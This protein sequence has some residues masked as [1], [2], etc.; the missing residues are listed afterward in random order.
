M[1]LFALLLLFPLLWPFLARVL[2]KHKIT[3]GEM[4][5]N[6]LVGALVVTVGWYAGR[7]SQMADTEILNG[8]VVSKA[9]ERVSCEHD[10]KCRCRQVCRGSGED[11]KCDEVCDTCY[12]HSHDL[13]WNLSTTLGDIEIDRVD[14][15][16]LTEPPRFTRAKPGD[17]VAQAHSFT[18]YIRGA[19][20]SLFNTASEVMASKQFKDDVPTY[21]SN[22]YDYHYVDRVLTVGVALPDL[23]EWNQDLAMRLRSLGPAKQVNAIVV[24]AKHSDPLYA[25][26]IRAMW[27][28]GKKNDV[29]VVLGVPNYPAIEW[30]RVVS[31]SDN[32]T[33]KVELRDDLQALKTANRENVLTIIEQRLAKQ[34]VRKPMK[35]F[36]YLL[37][38]IQPPG[39]V[40]WSLF[41]L[42][43]VVSIGA[44]VLL[45]R[46]DTRPNGFGNFARGRIRGL[47]R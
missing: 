41:A 44:S 12:D 30:A 1:E 16:G 17:P 4:G 33:F 20:D 19:Q 6:L 38:E 7:Y 31:W 11:R 10:Y 39:W 3:W 45:A 34:F 24:L 2:W 42:S 15:Q 18:N 26:A 46:N 13:K 29:I 43:V 32:E 22:V 9:P 14:R 28:G 35:D 36:E 27:L 40:L 25:S 23:R 8:Q 21:P 37:N 47:R 5:L